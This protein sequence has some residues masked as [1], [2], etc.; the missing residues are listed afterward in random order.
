VQTS[1]NEA[2]LTERTIASDRVPDVRGMGLRDALYLLENAGLNVETKGIGT[3][4]RQS[5]LPGT[6]LG[7]YPSIIIELS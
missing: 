5:L 7:I 1:S 3:V 4:R 2:Q 6:A